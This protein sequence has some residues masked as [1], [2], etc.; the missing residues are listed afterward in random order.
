[1]NLR[2]SD[3]KEI[4]RDALKGHWIS[5]FF[6]ALTAA[7]FGAFCMSLSVWGRFA[8]LMAAGVRYLEGVPNYIFLILGT[9]SCLAFFQFFL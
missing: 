1:M 9:G 5:A 7:V 4:A 2:S 6:A 3:I 8:A